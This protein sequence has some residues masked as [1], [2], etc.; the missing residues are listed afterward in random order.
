MCAQFFCLLCDNLRQLGKASSLF[1]REMPPRGPFQ[2][3][4]CISAGKKKKSECFSQL[5]TSILIYCHYQYCSKKVIF[6]I[7]LPCRPASLGKYHSL[8]YRQLQYFRCRYIIK[9]FISNGLSWSAILSMQ[10]RVSFQFSYR[11]K[12]IL[13]LPLFSVHL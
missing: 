7:V 8:L 3:A 11:I 12:H 4:L 10:V 1:I 2:K 9:N 6:L 5:Y 13:C